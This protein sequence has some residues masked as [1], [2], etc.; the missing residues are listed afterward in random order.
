MRNRMTS[1]TEIKHNLTP[2]TYPP[3]L[4]NVR[5]PTARRCCRYPTIAV[6]L[7][8]VISESET[9][10]LKK[11]SLAHESIYPKDKK[12]KEKEALAKLSHLKDFQFSLH[13]SHQTWR[14]QCMECHLRIK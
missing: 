10:T 3:H 5:E 9:E 14:T 4:L 13:L 1:E 8:V 12:R 6:F 7:D 11:T 2:Y